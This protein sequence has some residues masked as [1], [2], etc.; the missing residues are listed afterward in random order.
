MKKFMKNLAAAIAVVLAITSCSEEKK[1]QLLLPNITGKAG[2]IIVVIDKGHW[3]GVVGTAIRDSLTAETPFLP[4]PE[5]LFTLVNVPRNA[6]N[7]MFQVHRNVLIVNIDSS[8]TEPGMV[9]KKDLWAAPQTVIYINAA[10]SETA[11]KII[12]ENSATLVTTLEQ[13]EIDR[14]IRNIKKYEEPKI[15]T[16]V[17]EM[18]GGAP[19]FPSGYK[20]KKR[21]SDFI[22]AE[23]AT[24]GVTQGVLVYKYPVVE[25]EDMMSLESIIDNSNEMLKNN[26]PGMFENTY[27]TTSN[28]LRPGIEYKRYKGLAFAEVRGF[29][30][31][32]N[33]YMG[34]PF[35]SHAFYSQDGKDVI[36]MEGFVYAPKYDKRQYLRQVESIIYSFEWTSSEKD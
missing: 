28:A 16:A 19:H 15:A 7:S 23:Y 11:A 35:V 12:E 32:Y 34:G 22:W 17:T 14:I 8:V 25:G 26:V 24:Q 18:V 27:M 33:D 2:E 6:F 29:W 31:V 20:L 13:A 5:P 3:E 9:L 4:Q 30:E 36:V 1:K 10:D 21:T